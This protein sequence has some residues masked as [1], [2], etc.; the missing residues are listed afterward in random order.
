MRKVQLLLLTMVFL[1]GI[2]AFIAQKF[3]LDK[4]QVQSAISE[5]Q[6]QNKPHLTPRPTMSPD[7]I[8]NREKS[9]LDQLVK[10]GKITSDQ[11]QAILN[12]LAALS[13]KYNLGS[14]SGQTPDQRRSQMQAMQNDLKTW[15]Q[16]Q[17]INYAYVMPFGMG[18][19]PGGFG[20]PQRG[21]GPHISPTPTP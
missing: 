7:Q 12:E 17:G 15:A 6:S 19:R 20:G 10:G 4:T 2:V 18:R 3:G 9:R 13:S 21:W 5:Y 16:S 1:D 11:E 14:S 8:Q